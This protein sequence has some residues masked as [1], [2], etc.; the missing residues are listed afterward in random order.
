MKEMVFKLKKKRKVWDQNKTWNKRKT[1]Y[2]RSGF[3]GWGNN[4]SEMCPARCL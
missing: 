2:T 1:L 3:N 4:R